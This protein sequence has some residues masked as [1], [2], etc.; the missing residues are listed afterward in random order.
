MCTMCAASRAVD[1]S[2]TLQFTVHQ[3]Y[4]V[5]HKKNA[6]YLKLVKFFLA[7]MKRLTPILQQLLNATKRLL[8]N[9][10]ELEL[11]YAN[12]L[13]CPTSPNVAITDLSLEANAHSALLTNLLPIMSICV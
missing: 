2:S 7:Y 11:T 9:V 3:Y 4:T 5:T 12:M 8:S 1:M 13:N 10:T 6:N